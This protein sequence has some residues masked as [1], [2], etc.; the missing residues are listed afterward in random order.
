MVLIGAR[1]GAAVYSFAQP[2]HLWFG[3]AR[4]HWDEA[5]APTL[6]VVVDAGLIARK[7]FVAGKARLA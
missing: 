7:Q 5:I 3:T 2:E 6:D 1:S 4:H